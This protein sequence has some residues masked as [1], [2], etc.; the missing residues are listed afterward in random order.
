MTDLEINRALALAIGWRE[1]QI[2][3]WRGD[4]TYVQVLDGVLWRHFHHKYA[5][6]IWPIAE[7][8][9]CFPEKVHGERSDDGAWCAWVP[10]P[11]GNE[12]KYHDNPATA[13]A[14]AVI[15]ACGEKK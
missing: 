11:Q 6:I 7:R 5:S 14:I 15:A 10:E 2:R 13:V 1:E 8:F 4:D 12:T 9:D 3:A